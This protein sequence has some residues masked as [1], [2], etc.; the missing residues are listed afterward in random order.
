MR[1]RAIDVFE[2]VGQEV[3][4]ASVPPGRA[5]VQRGEFETCPGWEPGMDMGQRFAPDMLKTIRI[6]RFDHNGSWLP[7]VRNVSNVGSRL[8]G[9]RRQSRA[10]LSNRICSNGRWIR[11]M[12]CWFAGASASWLPK[13]I[14]LTITRQEQDSSGEGAPGPRQA[15]SVR[16]NSAVN[17]A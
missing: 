1:V 17:P 13:N 2:S 4:A 6:Q 16:S 11:R 5:R 10:G 9:H 8:E 15:V 12:A 3:G 7:K 14:G